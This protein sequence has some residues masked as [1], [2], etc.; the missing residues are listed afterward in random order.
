MTQERWVQLSPREKMV[1]R[2]VLNGRSKREITSSA[3]LTEEDVT[4]TLRKALRGLTA[5]LDA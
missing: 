1:L 5:T 3:G 4:A 2:M